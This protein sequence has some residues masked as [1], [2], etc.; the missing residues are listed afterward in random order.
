MNVVHASAIPADVLVTLAFVAVDRPLTEM[1][2]I[3][4]LIAVSF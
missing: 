2:L 1:G 3:A 4:W